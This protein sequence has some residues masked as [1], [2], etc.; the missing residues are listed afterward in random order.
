MLA[1]CHQQ[2]ATGHYFTGRHRDHSSSMGLRQL[3]PGCA[4]GL[5]QTSAQPILKSTHSFALATV[6]LAAR[7]SGCFRGLVRDGRQQLPLVSH[8][9]QGRFSR[10]GQGRSS[11]HPICTDLAP[12]KA[13]RVLTLATRALALRRRSRYIA[14]CFMYD[15]GA[16]MQVPPQVWPLTSP[17]VSNG[18]RYDNSCMLVT[19]T[20][21]GSTFASAQIG[22]TR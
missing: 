15:S 1:T 14:V 16:Q 13:R 20:A 9:P 4:T 21:F 12:D 3:F 10:R 5:R 17:R 11:R 19:N 6:V 8:V 22:S 7:I 18:T 2:E